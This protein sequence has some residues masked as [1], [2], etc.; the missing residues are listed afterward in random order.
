MN[1]LRQ[2]VP[3]RFYVEYPDKQG[4]SPSEVVVR[5]C[6]QLVRQRDLLESA[7][8]SETPWVDWAASSGEESMRLL[9]AQQGEQSAAGLEY[10]ISEHGSR[11]R[12][13]IVL[14]FPGNA[15]RVSVETEGFSPGRMRIESGPLLVRRVMACLERGGVDG[16]IQVSNL[17]HS[18]SQDWVRR[19]LLGQGSHRMPVVYVPFAATRRGFVSPYMLAQELAGIAHV[20]YGLQGFHQAVAENLSDRL[21]CRQNEV[22]LFWPERLTPVRIRLRSVRYGR[23]NWGCVVLKVVAGLWSEMRTEELSFQALERRVL[24]VGSRVRI[25]TG[26]DPMT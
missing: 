15:G 14:V 13:R 24:N 1:G 20:V 2:M 18:F 8:D 4:Y 23:F 17:P 26:E 10:S 22:L 11:F 9:W 7:P 12:A 21:A 25:G 6:H 16:D 5:L 19:L 3:E